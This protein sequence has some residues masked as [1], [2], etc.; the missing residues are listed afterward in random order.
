MKAEKA[1]RDA[2]QAEKETHQAVLRS[3]K[4]KRFKMY[5]EARKKKMIDLAQKH[6]KEWEVAYNTFYGVEDGLEVND[7]AEVEV[8]IQ[9]IRGANLEDQT[10]FTT[11]KFSYL[12]E[13]WSQSKWCLEHNN[14]FH[15]Q[16]YICDFH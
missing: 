11:E 9:D 7:N 16:R 13:G 15:G 2:R 10:Y 12:P 1:E 6:G 14:Q 4:L 3:E 5:N 8:I